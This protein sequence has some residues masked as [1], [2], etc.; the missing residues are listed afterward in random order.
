MCDFIT[1]SFF[2]RTWMTDVTW[3]DADGR[4]SIRERADVEAD[5][6][7]RSIH[8]FGV[9]RWKKVR[10]FDRLLRAMADALAS[11]APPHAPDEEEKARIER[12]ADDIAEMRP[13]L[14]RNFPRSKAIVE[15]PGG[16]VASF[17]WDTL[18]QIGTLHVARSNRDLISDAERG[19]VDLA[20]S[21]GAR[22][23][24]R[25]VVRSWR[26]VATYELPL[27][28]PALAIG[29][30][31]LEAVH[32]K[33]FSFYER[34]DVAGILE[35]WHAAERPSPPESESGDEAF[36]SAEAE[37]EV[38][39]A[40]IATAPSVLDDGR[41]AGRVRS[42]MRLSVLRT[43]LERSFGCE[44]RSSKGSEMVFYRPGGQH[45]FVARHVSNP[46]I[47]AIAI[48]RML[49][50]LRIGVADWIRATG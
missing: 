11:A 12:M 20:L 31:V 40:S 25:C 26:S 1:W 47:P 46:L 2:E 24:L 27:P 33:L 14:V 21:I 48:Q 13:L 29:R 37:A 6:R 16:Y 35:R 8:T 44:A 30:I 7:A 17:G 50:K 32:A 23:M 4:P 5:V 9:Y 43:V 22:G 36:L 3:S 19:V 18:D 28:F 45:A 10:V 34:I 41:T 49:K 15:L 38:I 42:S 39:A